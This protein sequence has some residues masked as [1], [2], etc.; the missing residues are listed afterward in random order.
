[1][2]NRYLFLRLRLASRSFGTLREKRNLLVQMG[3]RLLYRIV[4][5]EQT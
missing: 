2:D 3:M 5:P 1:M 4:P